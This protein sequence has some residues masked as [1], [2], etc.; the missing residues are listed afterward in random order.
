[1]EGTS[2]GFL[3]TIS[4]I[5]PAWAGHFD[6]EDI[7]KSI[8][9]TSDG[10]RCIQFV[11]VFGDRRQQ[12]EVCLHASN[13]WLESVRIGDK[14][15]RN[16]N[17][18]SFNN[19]SLPGHVEQWVGDTIVMAIDQTI[20]PKEYAPDFFGTPRVF[21][22]C[23][24]MTKRSPIDV[25]QPAQQNPSTNVLDIELNGVVTFDGRV[26]NLKPLNNLYPELHREAIDLVSKW[27]FAPGT[28]DGK[29]GGEWVPE[30]V[31]HFKG[32]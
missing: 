6:H 9:E 27:T 3:P 4:Q 32:R 28:C 25:P 21:K 11:T 30:F 1:V 2:P 26:T 22:S 23:S 14:T 20:V 24:V 17:F 7:I 15:I 31:V 16:S 29:P 5:A 8:T 18:F 13:G 10:K 12:N 19:A